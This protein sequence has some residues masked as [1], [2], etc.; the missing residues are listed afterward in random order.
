M[1]RLQSIIRWLFDRPPRNIV[2]K[3]ATF[4]ES[5]MDYTIVALKTRDGQIF[6]RVGLGDGLLGIGYFAALLDNPDVELPFRLRDIVDA[7]W[8]GYRVGKVTKR[9]EPAREEWKFAS[10]LDSAIVNPTAFV[11]PDW[12]LKCTVCNTLV[13]CS[14][15]RP[16]K[17]DCGN[18]SLDPERADLAIKDRSSVQLLNLKRK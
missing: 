7:E 15:S 4:P 2:A 14:A 18:V 11:S 17:C 16:A 6:R 3:L 13:S 10:P 8:E 9:P 12:A 1:K 5:G